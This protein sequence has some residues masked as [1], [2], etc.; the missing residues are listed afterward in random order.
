MKPAVLFLCTGNSCRSQMAE[1]WLR[2]IA[3]EHCDVFSAGM[4]PSHLHPLAV[5][6]MREV[7]LDIS[8]QYSKS[9]ADL[10]DRSFAFV[11]TV[12]DNA[13]ESCP[14]FPGSTTRLHWSF[15]DPAGVVGSEEFILKTFR[16]VRDE[17]R[18]HILEFAKELPAKLQS[19]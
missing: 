14:I 6:M 18:E 8:K 3:G 9:L 19:S 15:E 1:G 7:G 11:I 10:S 2:S 5:Q 16:K 4:K 12:C 17:I 13:Q